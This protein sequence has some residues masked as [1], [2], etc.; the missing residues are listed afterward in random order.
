MTRPSP[1]FDLVASLAL[2]GAAAL[3]VVRPHHVTKIAASPLLQGGLAKRLAPPPPPPPSPVAKIRELRRLARRYAPPVRARM[4]QLTRTTGR[5]LNGSAALLAFSVLTDS[6]VEHYRGSFQNRAMYT[7]LIA[8]AVTLGASLLGLADTRAQK[9]A[10]RD[11]VYASAAATG[12]TGL[13][14]HFYNILKRPG[15]WSWLNLF[16]AAPIGAPMALALAGLIGR[17]AEQVRDTAPLDDATVLGLPAGRMLAAVTA[18][19]LAGTVGEAGLLHF[20]GAYHDPAMLLPV[21]VPP[22]ASAALA[23]AALR[24]SRNVNRLARWWLR[25]TALLGFAGVGFHAY[26][27]SRNMGGWRNWSQNVLNGPPLPAPPSFTGLAL[28]GLAALNL[29]EEAET[30]V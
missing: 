16:Y 30:D 11:V 17:G 29:I 9:H 2:A 12:F 1:A 4:R 6:A 14:F 18:A 27:V 8:A 25:M 15:G 10:A 24:P 28:A 19:G 23:A 3:I 20:R 21:T 22:L 5:K 7:P 26:G 13:G